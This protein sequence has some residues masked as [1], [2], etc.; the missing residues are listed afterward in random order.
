[1]PATNE[2]T[3]FWV[4]ASSASALTS[5]T[6]TPCFEQRDGAGDE[7]GAGHGQLGVVHRHHGLLGGAGMRNMLGKPRLMMP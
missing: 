5:K 7:L 6:S 2:S 3:I 4:Q 1:M